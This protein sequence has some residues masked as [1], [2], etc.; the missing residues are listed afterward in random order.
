MSK[1]TSKLQLTL[2]KRLADEHHIAPGDEVTFLSAGDS[3]RIVVGTAA[4]LDVEAR[5][6]SFDEATDRQRARNRAMR[7][8]T[9]PG[10][11]GWVREDLYDRARPR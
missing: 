8:G 11:R 9:K 4:P 10:A 1:V 5:L 2:P 3:I 7:R 6:R